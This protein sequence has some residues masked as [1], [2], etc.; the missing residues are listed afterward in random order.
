MFFVG[1]IVQISTPH[2]KSLAFHSA[3]KRIDACFLLAPV[4]A[5]IWQLNLPCPAM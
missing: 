1:H 4:C 2:R 3:V 5:A